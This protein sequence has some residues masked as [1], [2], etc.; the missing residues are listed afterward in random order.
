[1]RISLIFP[2]LFFLV[3]RLRTRFAIAFVIVLTLVGQFGEFLF[4]HDTFV[5]LEYA[6][7]FVVGI[8]LAKN[9]E[10]VSTWYRMRSLSLK[11]ALL[12]G[13]FLL[14]GQS[15]R[16][17]ASNL[18]FVWRLVD[19]LTVLGATGIVLTAL[20]SRRISRALRSVVPQFLGKI[21][22]SLYLIH[23]TVLFAMLM[24]CRKMFSEWAFLSV[25]FL[26]SLGIATVFYFRVEIP[27]I[28][29]S[30]RAGH[31][32]EG[33]EHIDLTNLVVPAIE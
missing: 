28:S 27:L 29:L 8:L 17:Q 13:S 31:W 32:I 2:G 11:S 1:M 12:T 24:L 26:C 6:A 23:G 14:Y 7:I 3:A 15:F 10:L 20:N 21:S 33:F 22:Y 4:T 25:Y 16:V 5:T 18:P 30:R 9:L 19:G